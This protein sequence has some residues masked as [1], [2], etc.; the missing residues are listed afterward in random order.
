[1][2][3]TAV[4]I[5]ANNHTI[6]VRTPSHNHHLFWA[7][8]RRGGDRCIGVRVSGLYEI[9]QLSQFPSPRATHK[10]NQGG[11]NPKWQHHPIDRG[12]VVQQIFD[13]LTRCGNT[14]DGGVVNVVRPRWNGRSWWAH[15]G[16]LTFQKLQKRYHGDQKDGGKDACEAVA[17]GKRTEHRFVSPFGTQVATRGNDHAKDGGG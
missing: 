14:T 2:L 5:V 13:A 11:H 4:G 15:R 1:M 3:S 17:D 7:Q 8:Y 16:V 10:S 6:A 12:I 9:G